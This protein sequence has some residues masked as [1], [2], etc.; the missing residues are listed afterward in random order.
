MKEADISVKVVEPK[1]PHSKGSAGL[2]TQMYGQAV[3]V[4][5]FANIITL[6]RDKK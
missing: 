3:T 4:S 1:I 2:E 6:V 5:A